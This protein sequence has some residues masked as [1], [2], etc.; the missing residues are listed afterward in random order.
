MA[1]LDVESYHP[2]MVSNQQSVSLAEYSMHGIE[3]FH[4]ISY[5]FWEEHYLPMLQ[6]CFNFFIYLKSYILNILDLFILSCVSVLLAY[7][8][9]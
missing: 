5:V 9:V 7:S 8:H 2:V 3:I 4:L 6:I 1:S